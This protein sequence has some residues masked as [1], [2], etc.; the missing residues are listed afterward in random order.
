MRP[1][2]KH[3]LGSEKVPSAQPPREMEFRVL[4]SGCDLSGC[5]MYYQGADKPLDFALM[6]Q[7]WRKHKTE[8]R[9]WNARFHCGLP[10]WAHRRWS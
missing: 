8:V 4:A 1:A 5:S 2:H 7:H 3:E 9:E 6:R 10:I